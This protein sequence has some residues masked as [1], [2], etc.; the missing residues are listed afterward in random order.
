MADVSLSLR[1]KMNFDD[2][3]SVLFG[4]DYPYAFNVESQ[5]LGAGFVDTPTLGTDK[6][7]DLGVQALQNQRVRVT[8]PTQLDN[9]VS[10]VDVRLQNING[11]VLAQGQAAI[12]KDNQNIKNGIA[13]VLNNNSPFPVTYSN[14]DGSDSFEI[15]INANFADWRLV[16]EIDDQVIQ[17]LPVVVIQEAVDETGTGIFVPTGWRRAGDDLLVYSTTQREFPRNLGNIL[18][19]SGDN[20]G[21]V[22]ITMPFSHELENLTSVNIG[23]VLGSPGINGTWTIFVVSN[24]TFGLFNSVFQG[25]NPTGGS[26]YANVYGYGCIGL[27]RYNSQSDDY[28]YTKLLRSKKLNFNT[29]KQIDSD[30]EVS[31]DRISAYYTDDYNPPRNFYYKGEVSEDGAINAINPANIYNYETL[32]IQSQNII[33]YSNYDVEVVL[34]QIQTGGNTPSGTLRYSVQFLTENFTTTENS[35]LTNIIHNYIQEYDPDDPD[36]KVFGSTG[37]TPKIN[38]IRVSGITPNVFKYVELVC[39]EYSG[40]AS[41]QAINSF[42]VRREVLE[43]GQTEIVL[44]HNG[45]EPNTLSYDTG[46]AGIIGTFIK[47]CKSLRIVDNRLVKAN[48]TTHAE[49]DLREWIEAFNYRIIRN[50]IQAG[51]VGRDFKTT[52]EF[53]DPENVVN[54]VGYMPYEWYRFYVSA[55]FKNNQ[56]SKSFFYA[57]VRFLPYQEYI[58]PASPFFDEFKETNKRDKRQAPPSDQ[59][60]I[61]IF[62]DGNNIFQYGIEVTDIDWSF[63]IDGV[64]ASDLIDEIYIERRPVVPEVLGAGM[65]HLT[66]LVSLVPGQGGV[67]QVEVHMPMYDILTGNFNTAVPAQQ[68]QIISQAQLQVINNVIIPAVLSP[69]S[70]FAFYCPDWYFTGQYPQYTQGDKVIGVGVMFAADA[71]AGAADPTTSRYLYLGYGFQTSQNTII[72]DVARAVFVGAGQ[73]KT[74]ETL[75]NIVTA[76]TTASGRVF[77]PDGTQTNDGVT[78]YG[79]YG[80]RAS[81]LLQYFQQGSSAF[82]RAAYGYYFRPRKEKYGSI[83]SGDTEYTGAKALAGES[84]ARVFGGDTFYQ[85]TS[86]KYIVTRNALQG[87]GATYFSHNRN[88]I[89]LRLYDQNQTTGLNSGV[90]YGLTAQTLVQW[91]APIKF[92]QTRLNPSYTTINRIQSNPVFDPNLIETPVMKTRIHYSELKPQN[93]IKDNYREF[94]P[95][96]FRDKDLTDGGI[97]KVLNVNGRLMVFQERNMSVEYFDSSGRMRVAEGGDVIFGDGSVLSRRGDDLTIYGTKHQFAI[98]EGASVGG[99]TTLYWINTD[100]SVMGRFGADGTVDLGLR[101][102][103]RTFFMENTR[104]AK[105]ALTPADGFGIT[106]IWDARKMQ[107]LIT[108][109]AWDKNVKEWGG[110][111]NTGVSIPGQGAAYPAGTVRWFLR[112]QDIPIFYITKKL[113]PLTVNPFFDVQQGGEFWERIPFTNNNYYNVWTLVYSEKESR[114]KLFNGFYPKFYM[115]LDERYFSA[116][117]TTEKDIHR[118]DD[119]EPLVFYGNEQEGYITRVMNVAPRVPKKM[120]AL[121]IQSTNKPFRVECEAEHISYVGA[122]DRKAVMNDVDFTTQQNYNYAP[123]L[124]N[125]VDGSSKGKTEQLRGLYMKVKMFFKPRQLQIV[126]DITVKIREQFKNV[127][128]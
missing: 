57:D 70:P 84:S 21:R 104:F 88:N 3:I 82:N 120:V 117:P 127:K 48:I 7:I 73:T 1:G 85:Q 79:Y 69:N 103:M 23:G 11:I 14:L 53:Y 87:V 58:D 30:A 128:S 9:S 22:L 29:K 34:P 94:L 38:R 36:K 111:E 8:I 96:N 109:R 20:Q 95:F 92:D 32:S 126:R 18:S 118:H 26:I 74:F 42:I 4:G 49:T 41:T 124:N 80:V 61:N 113:T 81:G 125:F 107:V 108:C 114:F 83:I 19:I 115:Q 35:R 47:T 44:E 17:S 90:P 62:G 102:K 39:H 105:D 31:N 65:L 123:I 99:K 110:R 86:L 2:D 28:T 93:S 24:N 98:V 71:V 68:V 40:I 66:R 89:N 78:A 13:S 59:Y 67:P 76:I 12:V 10:Q 52:G 101:D 54:N 43:E 60:D 97:T 106:G 100:Y 6:K 121:A 15:Q 72:D 119:N 37:L 55:K 122:S 33:D 45:N 25:G 51:S 63:L 112:D 50:P 27:V 46:E 77:N 56:Q 16:I 91:L 75:T 5:N 64:L 116:D